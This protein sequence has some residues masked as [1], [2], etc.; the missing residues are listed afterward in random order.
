MGGNLR[1]G[2]GA[3]L[4]CALATMGVAFV[5]PTSAFAATDASVTITPA[6]TTVASGT[7]V[8]YTMSV[9]CSLPSG[10]CAGAKVT[11]PSTAI[12]GDGTTTDFTSMVANGTCATAGVT[13]SAS[14]GVV[15][16]T[17]GSSLPS[18]STSNCTF[19]VTPPNLTTLNNTQITITPT[20]GGTNFTSSTGTAVTLTSTAGHKAS[21]NQSVSVAKNVI[22]TPYAYTVGLPCGTGT[23]DT[24]M[25]SITV[26]EQLPAGF[27]YDHT[28]LFNPAPGTVTYDA[29]TNT[30]TYSDPTGMSCG[31]NVRVFGTAATNGIPD[32]AGTTLCASA[33]STFT[34][35][36][37]TPGTATSPQAC[38]T[39][40]Q[41]ITQTTK[42]GA[43][44][45]LGNVGQYT[46]A[47]DGR[48]YPYTF[49]G[50][51]DQSG[52]S[53]TWDLFVA[54]NPVSTQSEVAYQVQ[55][56]FPCLDN[57]S[58]GIYTSSPPGAP[59]C[60]HPAFV[61][62]GQVTVTGFAPT[63][64]DRMTVDFVDGTSTTVA[65]A[66]GGWAI[67]T[68]KPIA[69]IDFP[70][71]A[72]EGTNTATGIHFSVPGYAAATATPNSLLR[73]TITS[74]AFTPDGSAEVDIA[75]Q[76]TGNVLVADPIS[77]S[78]TIIYPSLTAQPVTGTT[79]AENVQL[80]NNVSGTFTNRIEFA[81]GTSKQIQI[82]ILLP[83]GA[84]V[85]PSD[86]SSKFTEKFTLKGLTNGQSFT[87]S[88]AI[89]PTVVSNFNGTGRDL[90]E[91]VIPAG[92]A[93][94]PGD[95][96]ITPANGNLP[97]TLPP[98]CAGT[99]QNDITVGYDGPVDHCYFNNG[100]SPHVTTPPMNP[101]ADNDLNSNSIGTN[102]YCGF[103]S[104]FTVA[105]IN[106]G[107]T[108]GKTVQGN[109]DA[110]PV[111]NGGVGN[112]SPTGGTA[113]Y[114]V[115]FS[116]SPTGGSNLTDPVLYDLL[117]RVGDT[118]ATS[119]TARGSQFD[120]SLASVGPAPA[121]V[122]VSY[123]TATNPC[124]PEVLANASNP[125]CVDDWSTTPPSPLSSVTA[126]KF[127][128]SGTIVVTAGAGTHSFTVPYTVTTPAVAGG[129]IAWNTVGATAM[130][131]TTQLTA[132]ESSRTGL[133]AE[134]GLTI[135]KASPTANYTHPGDEVDYSYTVTNT[136]A[137]E[138]DG[139]SVLDNLVG[140]DAGDVAPT[141]TCQSLAT[142]AGSC[143]SAASTTLAA[144]QSATFVASYAVT[145]PD[146][147]AG[148][149]TDT[150]TA[151]G[152]PP[153]GPPATATSNPVTVP[154]VL[155]P[156]TLTLVKSADVASVSAVGDPITFQYLVTDTS[157]ATATG[158]SINESDFTGTGTL[159]APS[160]PVTT[161]A[162][163]AS[164]TCTATYAATQDD[165][166]AGSIS[167]TATA[168]AIEA[169]QAVTTDPSTAT[170]PA[171]QT[172]GL[173]LTKTATPDTVS[174]AGGQIEF[175][176]L[177]TNTGNVT[178]SAVAIIE[179]SFTGSGTL[180]AVSCPSTTIAAGDNETCTATYTV[181]QADLDAGSFGNTATAS[182]TE[183]GAT[184]TSDPSTATVTATQNPALTLTKSANPTTAA[185]VGDPVSYSF[186]VTN[187]GN[188]TVTGVGIDETAFS[189]SGALSAISCPVTTLAPTATTTCTATYAATQADLNAGTITN[190]ATATGTPPTGPAVTSAP[191]TA[192]VTATQTATLT[193]TKS[194]DP[195]TVFAAG[196]PLS[197]SFLVT[198]TG[199][200]TVSSIAIKESA[201]TGSGT[202]SAISCPT[203][204]LAPTDAETCT[205][206][207]SVTQADL[208]A[209]SIANTATATGTG[210]DGSPV[211]STESSAAVTAT[212]TP[213][214]SLVK[215][216]DPSKVSKVGDAVSYSFVV[217]NT[218]N[219]T[220]SSI[221][222][223]ESSFTGASALS[224]INCPTPSLAPGEDETCTAIYLVTQ[225]DLDAGTVA[226][227]ASA[228]GTAPGGTPVASA[229]STATVTVTQIP[230]LT[231][232]KSADPPGASTYKAG[233]VITYSFAVTNTG[234]VTESNI[235]IDEGAFTGSGTVSTP[236][237]PSATLVPASQETCTASYT[238]TQADIDSG[239]IENTATAT[240]TDP[241]GAS[242]TSPP[243]SVTTPNT[244]APALTLLKSV[245]PAKVTAPGQ[246]VTYSFLITNT[247]TVTLAGIKVDEGSFSG[248]GTLSA[249]SCPGSS[250]APGV[251]LTCTATYAIT[252]KDLAAGKVTNT[253]TATGREGPVGATQ[254]VDSAASTANLTA[255]QPSPPGGGS[256]TG[257]GSDLS[258]TGTDALALGG[259]ALALIVSGGLVLL[260]GRRR[261]A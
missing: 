238:L 138:L 177:I 36:D 160:C 110:T 100:V 230:A 128:Y 112:V 141:V 251:K 52:A 111:S 21:L 53:V 207:Y 132:A 124:R 240:G 244:P 22:G 126:L 257:S 115:T 116:N 84:T 101:F 243:S 82:N 85:S 168:S 39:T 55:D 108:V 232:V 24:G 106:P 88:A 9:T 152:T 193:L 25:S 68:T 214:L 169:G 67:P 189:G 236:S 50:N 163:N 70:P 260:A 181:T 154:A 58:G 174:A 155:L 252:A 196:D 123:S 197:Y 80:D 158:V 184:V 218:G 165:L 206:T 61:P 13:E 146:V 242:I 17:Y 46:F 4:A 19:K 220:V 95:Y 15:T 175:D 235:A 153:V 212:Q 166:D 225:A 253:A 92:L 179:G 228:T 35:L 3:T 258:S 89:A 40:V 27:T 223:D 217:T 32:P 147:D 6:T 170:V 248:T 137:V 204:S 59:F 142:P 162:P 57:L 10:S 150:A 194:A 134:S 28:Q 135:T 185:A 87:T 145:Q 151:T 26:T 18:G 178:A 72:E 249:I 119:T 176:Y 8:T 233:Q 173:T 237:C 51:W 102:Q 190:T 44:V 65:F 219:Q 247:G 143:T 167:N 11:F 71:F 29:A 186:L 205:A 109:L 81:S 261:R 42:T 199:N 104:T 1:R 118:D 209:G 122:T 96:V 74:T 140:A 216:A 255:R 129:D 2:L 213:A 256:P 79:C 83:V 226:N 114:N 148:Q 37:G 117:P 93:T 229:D 187:T 183:A 222:I 34:Y 231:V 98:G 133:Q 191:S 224:A 125:G 20:I 7:A 156:P 78:G 202:L 139:V 157:N 192:T 64:A 246:T 41:L 188:V 172:A 77:A 208:D 159:S 200:V 130:A 31:G 38:T 12:T 136:T 227:T 66:S 73:N 250:L 149:I 164:T 121:G 203:L 30:I 113:T 63:A 76:A 182:A 86:L 161:L 75:R 210:P 54:T 239:S 62:S 180:G 94:V 254:A 103:S 48:A 127:T 215:T 105:P 49:P 91:W 69:E 144:G 171:I 198:N 16:F 195:T 14:G 221:A 234:N 23:G 45:T 131:G 120:V 245:S 99:Y 107:F 33:T 60:A 90:Y 5:A 97:V 47:G 259:M 211:T 201:F 43:T 241:G 56:P